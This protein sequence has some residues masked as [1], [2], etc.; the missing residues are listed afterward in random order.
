MGKP[1][2][3]SDSA[4]QGDR[5]I[6]QSMTHVSSARSFPDTC[7]PIR[8]SR[9]RG[10]RVLALVLVLACLGPIRL[11]GAGTLPPSKTPKQG[12]KHPPTTTEPAH[13]WG[14]VRAVFSA[15]DL[16][17]ATP[18]LADVNVRLLGVEPPVVSRAASD[19]TKPNP[20]QPFG[21]Q[22][23]GRPASTS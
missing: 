8:L 10:W 14:T 13:G 11:G 6:A 1:P 2:V 18:E 20:A 12:Q 17:V 3:G 5:E 23:T 15:A 4:P 9:I 19:G 21:G 16:V 22:A 7:S